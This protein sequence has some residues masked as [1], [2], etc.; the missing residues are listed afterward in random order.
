MSNHLS[1]EQFARCAAGSPSNAEL[2]HASEC[3]ECRAELEQFGN[4]LS[5]F[6]RAIRERIDDR[7]PVHSLAITPLS[8][9]EVSVSRWRWAMVAAAIFALFIPYFVAVKEPRQE[10]GQQAIIDT[11]PDAVMDRVNLHLSRTVPAPME[12]IM[13]L[14]P[15]QESATKTGG[16]Q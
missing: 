3:P 6:R 2:Q 15:S 10:N 5:Q 16:V 14:I 12:P 4:T 9:T 11:N 1:P 7:V 13:S 8:R